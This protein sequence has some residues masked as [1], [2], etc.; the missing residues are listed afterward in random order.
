[1]TVMNHGMSNLMKKS[2]IFLFCVAFFMVLV[3]CPTPLSKAMAKEVMDSVDPVIKVVTPEDGDA[4][5]AYTLITGSVSDEADGSTPGKVTSLYVEILGVTGGQGISVSNNGSFSVTLP[6]NG[7]GYSSDIVV[8]LTATDWNGNSSETTMA[9]RKAAGEITGFTV[10]AGNRNA[11]INWDPLPEAESYTLKEFRSGDSVEGITGTSYTWEDLVNG[12]KCS[13]RVE[14]EIDGEIY[15]SEIAEAIPLAES[16][17]TPDVESV[18]RGI[19]L[20]WK[21][22]PAASEYVIE[23]SENR[24]GPFSI[25]TITPNS[26][27]LDENLE[28]GESFYYRIYPVE[29]MDNPDIAIS[30]V[31]YGCAGYFHGRDDYSILSSVDTENSAFYTVVLG[32]YAYIADGTDGLWIADT[33]DIYNPVIVSSCNNTSKDTNGDGYGN[34]R[35]VALAE[36]GNYAYIANL[37]SG[38]EIID[39]S[40]KLNPYRLQLDSDDDYPYDY[41]TTAAFGIAVFD[42]TINS[43][44]NHYACIA[45]GGAGMEIVNVTD[46]SSLVSVYDNDTSDAGRVTVAENY[47]Y[48]TDSTA[49]VLIYEINSTQNDPSN[50]SIGDPVVCHDV[51]SDSRDVAVSGDYA[52]VAEL[53]NG[54]NIFKISDQS[55]VI[56]FPLTNH[57]LGVAVSGTRAYVAN[58]ISG[59]RIIDVSDPADPSIIT[60]CDT[61]GDAQ[62]VTIKGDYAFVADYNSGLQIVDISEP[63]ATLK[64]FSETG[65]VLDCGV[66]ISGNYAFVADGDPSDNSYEA[67]SLKVFS[68]SSPET[69]VLVS[70]ISSGMENC[71]GVIVSGDYAYVTDY[72]P[73]L[74]VFDISDPSNPVL[75]ATCDIKVTTPG[76]SMEVA[77]SG[78]YAYVAAKDNGLQI[79]DISDPNNP[80]R[81]GLCDMDEYALDVAISGTHAYVAG[82]DSGLIVMDISDPDHPY[83]VGSHDTAGNAYGVAVAGNYVYIAD[84]TTGLVI[85]DIT[86]P[87]SITDSSTAYT[88]DT[89][90][91]ATGVTISGSY[92][93]VADGADGLNVID[94]SHPEDPT[95]LIEITSVDTTSAQAVAVA[96]RY[97]YVADGSGGLVVV[98]LWKDQSL[99]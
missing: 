92:A 14:A 89:D 99:E 53:D 50:L 32:D 85:L 54:L 15:P 22:I 73:G 27:F 98:D 70:T 95:D 9:L 65:T 21:D 36:D 80:V 24:N 86:T 90:G 45:D 13:F 75:K 52:Y 44:L 68:L 20:S 78:S 19:R 2:V 55:H 23:R 59:L 30:A 91:T 77:V 43:T 71:T 51:T 7:A 40:D 58:G 72:N 60:T 83:Q 97:A 76:R 28:R 12:S 1:M 57:A 82:D 5:G 17:L 96:G 48:L 16:T 6:T 18:Y 10:T 42:R 29:R 26:T 4:F 93:F 49:G 81:A 56:N 63:S 94:V 87:E 47:I 64:P 69:P 38:M 39:I 61:P 79:V 37:K 8:K 31:T 84:G 66:A 74:H 46:P 25:R 33:S 41:E 3:S 34:A 35:G 67:G 11:V 62:A 88:F